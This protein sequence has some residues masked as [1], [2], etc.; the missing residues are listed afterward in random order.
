MITRFQKCFFLPDFHATVYSKAQEMETVNPIPEKAIKRHLNQFHKLYNEVS[1]LRMINFKTQQMIAEY[2]DKEK[3]IEEIGDGVTLFDYENTK[4]KLQ[5]L[6]SNIDAKN[7]VLERMRMRIQRDKIDDEKYTADLKELDARLQKIEENQR[8]LK[9]EHTK[10]SNESKK[11]KSLEKHLKIKLNDIYIKGQLLSERSLMV[12]Y[13]KMDEK[14]NEKK[15]EMTT[16]KD[17]NQKL[18]QKLRK[19]EEELK[20]LEVEKGKA[21]KNVEPLTL[22]EERVALFRK[23][24]TS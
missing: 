12:D 7:K 13:D 16:L 17:E 24:R 2:I 19:Y 20:T 22:Y 10:L 23:T 21:Q 18:D 6:N 8:K 11:L 15:D 14:F 9:A 5:I 4:T 1:N 3:T